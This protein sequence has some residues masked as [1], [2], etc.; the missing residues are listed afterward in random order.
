MI[1][2]STLIFCL[3]PELQEAFEG[4]KIIQI[5]FRGSFGQSSDKKELLFLTRSKKREVSLLFSAHPE[6]YRIEILDENETKARESDYQK[7]NLFS[8]AVGG[9]ISEISQVD[10]DR[11]IKISCLKKSQL[12][13]NVEFDLIFELTGRNSNLILLRKDGLIINCLRKIDFTQSRFRQILP[14]E[15]YV[16]PPH[17]K[18]KN[19]FQIEKEKFLI[20]LKDNDLLISEF[21]I[22]HFIGLDKPLAETIIFEAGIPL[23]AKTADLKEDDIERLWKSFKGIFQKLSEHKLTFHIITDEKEK[24][25]TI[26][27]VN[28]SFLKDD[29]KIFCENLNSAI[30]KFFHQKLEEHQRKT[31]LKRLFEVAHR[32]QERLQSKKEKIEEDLEQAEKFEQYKKFGV[33]LMMN[34]DLIEK[35][36]DSIKLVDIFKPEQSFIEIP[37]NEKLSPI[38]N[39]QAYFKK[40][41]KAKDALAVMKKRKAETEKEIHKLEKLLEKLDETTKELKLEEIEQELISLGFLKDRKFF[42]RRKKSKSQDA[43]AKGF[44]PKRFVTKDGGEILVGRNN[45]ENDY[46]TFKFARPDDLWFHAQDVPGSHVLLRRKEK[47]KEPSH[48]DIK[49]V[50]Q[51]AAYFSK[52]RREKNA[53]VIYTL[54]KYVKKPKKGKPGLALVEREKAI[55]VEPKL[56]DK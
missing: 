6:N 34:K 21:L 3:I 40:Y 33:L 26:S 45:K 27:C 25:K 32:A 30:K 31:D 48:I 46:L 28:P 13:T 38:Q 44:S 43:F 29:Q 24:P 53:S 20:L 14:G 8:Y 47:K 15:R 51:I 42:E 55:W 52:A 19:P 1:I 36:Q 12:G 56:T 54:S 18:R 7:T 35:G 22:S 41:K 49:E 17:P 37:L 11:V 10:F 4:N 16:P 5:L 2:N 39:A 9:H 50:A 23:N